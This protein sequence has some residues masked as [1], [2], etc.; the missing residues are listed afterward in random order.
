[1]LNFSFR[2]VKPK[3]PAC[4]RSVF[5]ADNPCIVR[6]TTWSRRMPIPQAAAAEGGW[7]CGTEGGGAAVSFFT[8]LTRICGS[9]KKKKRPT[10]QAFSLEALSDFPW[11]VQAIKSASGAFQQNFHGGNTLFCTV[12]YINGSYMWQKRKKKQERLF[13]CCSSQMCK[14]VVD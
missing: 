14:N 1:M 5:P 12:R 6:R 10:R 9:K 3:S 13:W 7:Q 2:L 11:R 4:D 8:Q